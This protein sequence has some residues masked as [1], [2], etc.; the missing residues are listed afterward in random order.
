MPSLYKGNHSTYQSYTWAIQLKKNL[1][2]GLTQ[3]NAQLFLPFILS[4]HNHNKISN[5]NKILQS[6]NLGILHY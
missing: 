3:C 6:I 4:K 5:N 2:H 1:T